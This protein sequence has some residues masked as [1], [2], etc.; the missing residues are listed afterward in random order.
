MK[1]RSL[2][3][4]FSVIVLSSC[5]SDEAKW[6]NIKSTTDVYPKD[7][8]SS[9]NSYSEE[10]EMIRK[11]VNEAYRNYEY[12]KY[13]N[14]IAEVTFEIS[15][16]KVNI[17]LYRDS[18]SIAKRLQSD[19]RKDGVAHFVGQ[20]LT[21]GELKIYLYYEDGLNP[22][23]KLSDFEIPNVGFMKSDPDWKGYSTLL[24]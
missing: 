6:Q 22:I 24:P 23:K 1:S 10:G 18:F 15:N 2:L 3:A 17:Y 11:W 16:S 21:D 20:T 19:F 8:I 9:Y 7:S 5:N 12:K 14:N 4:F 13:C